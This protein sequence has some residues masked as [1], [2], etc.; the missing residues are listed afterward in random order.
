MAIKAIETFYGGYRF[1]SRLEAR[2]SVFFDE[3]GLDWQ[4]EPQ[5]FEITLI[6]KKIKYL[7]DFWLE[8]GQWAEVKG[9]LDLSAMLRLYEIAG[10]LTGCGGNDLVIFGNI[11]KR[12]SIK[13]PVQLH[14]HG[15]HL[16]GAA[17]DPYSEECAAQRPHVAIVPTLEMAEH[18]T[19][20]FPFGRPEWAEDG[21]E[22]ARKA[23][24]EWGEHG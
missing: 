15:R 22:R 9:F 24:F 8:C 12:F 16:W 21:L 2:W 6:H 23:R 14:A 13:W 10:A 1:R 20:G 5:G 4:Y 17:W 18:L 11:P 7:P 19:D 3:C